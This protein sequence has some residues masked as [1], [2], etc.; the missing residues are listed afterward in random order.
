[1]S[2][3]KQILELVTDGTSVGINLDNP[4]MNEAFAGNYDGMVMAYEELQ[5]L[6]EQAIEDYR[7]D[8]V[9]DRYL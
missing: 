1:M 5:L 3:P 9:D 8:F 7:P 4:V 2:E 6:F